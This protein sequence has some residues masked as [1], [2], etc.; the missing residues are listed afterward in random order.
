M[1][2]PDA[3]SQ[4]TMTVPEAGRHLGLGRSAAYAAVRSGDLPSF[5][6]G[7][8]LRIRTSDV[9]R[10]VGLPPNDSLDATAVASPFG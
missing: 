5:R 9:C 6:I 2:L 4:P 8:R 10:L 3:R 7:S 1:V